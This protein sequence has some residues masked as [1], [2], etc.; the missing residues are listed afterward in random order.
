MAGHKVRTRKEWLAAGN[1][2]LAKEKELT[3]R[4]DQ[5]AAERRQ[6]PWVPIGKSYSFDTA[7]GP[8]TLAELSDGRSQL[9]V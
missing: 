6:L 1:E 3:Q 5:L 7:A 2:L 8:K 4:S 9:L